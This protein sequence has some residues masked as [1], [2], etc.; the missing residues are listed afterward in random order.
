MRSRNLLIGIGLVTGVSALILV[1]LSLQPGAK[2]DDGRHEGWGEL[3]TVVVP[4][5]RIEANQRLDPLVEQG[6]FEEIKIP[7][8]ALVDGA[9]TEVNDL[10]G[11]TTTTPVLKNEQISTARLWNGELPGPV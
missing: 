1:T 2:E 9:I 11:L 8:A 3:V 7:K 4:K 6:M 5:Q 10:R